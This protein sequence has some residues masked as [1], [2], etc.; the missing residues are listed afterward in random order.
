MMSSPGSAARSARTTVS[1]PTPESKTPIGLRSLAVP[2]AMAMERA[3]DTCH[4]IGARVGRRCCDDLA[5]WL[6]DLPGLGGPLPFSGSAKR[7][8]AAPARGRGDRAAARLGGLEHPH[9]LQ[10]CRRLVREGA[11]E[12]TDPREALLRHRQMTFCDATLHCAGRL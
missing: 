7:S 10:E 4:S 2:G 12:P 1:P 8:A 9:E 6:V 11:V 5:Q 3:V